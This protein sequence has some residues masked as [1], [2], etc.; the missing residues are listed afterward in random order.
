MA[1]VLIIDDDEML[2]K[3]SSRYV[4]QMGHNA[5]CALSLREGIEQVSS[6]TFDLVF[7]DVQFPD[8]NGLDALPRIRNT[9]SP[10]VR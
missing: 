5:S 3:T 2:C 1:E 8:G 4:N 10:P 9:A 6:R 7:L